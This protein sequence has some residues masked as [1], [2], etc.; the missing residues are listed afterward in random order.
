MDYYHECCWWPVAW[1]TVDR[2]SL[3]LPGL[4]HKVS[5]N[6]SGNAAA[7]AAAWAL[8]YNQHESNE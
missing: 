3:R 7:A 2:L 1:F 4:K 6:M 8:G 5:I